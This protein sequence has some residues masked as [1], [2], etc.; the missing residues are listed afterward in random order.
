MDALFVFIVAMFIAAP[1]AASYPTLV[2]ES[3][4]QEFMGFTRSHPFQESTGRSSSF[5]GSIAYAAIT[6]S[7]SSSD[8][9][10]RMDSSSRF[11]RDTEM[12]V[13][14]GI[15][16]AAID[17]IVGA[18]TIS[19]QNKLEMD[20]TSLPTRTRV[21]GN[22]P[23][24]FIYDERGICLAVWS[25]SC[26]LQSFSKA[27][28]SPV[29]AEVLKVHALCS[30]DCWT[31]VE[32]PELFAVHVTGLKFENA[33]E[34]N[35]VKE[36][37][38]ICDFMDGSPSSVI[39]YPTV[40]VT[41][42]LKSSKQSALFI[43]AQNK[44]RMNIASPLR[45]T[46]E[47]PSRSLLYGDE[48]IECVTTLVN[49]VVKS[50]RYDWKSIP[51]YGEFFVCRLN[52]ISAT[53]AAWNSGSETVYRNFFPEPSLGKGATWNP[54]PQQMVKYQKVQSDFLIFPPVC[55]HMVCLNKSLSLDLCDPRR[56]IRCIGYITPVYPRYKYSAEVQ[57]YWALHGTEGYR[58]R[59]NPE[60]KY[61][62]GARLF[63]TQRG[64]KGY[65]LGALPKCKYSVV[66]S[67]Q[68]Q[69]GTVE[70]H[71]GTSPMMQ[72][73]AEGKK[74]VASSTG[75]LKYSKCMC[76]A[77]I[78]KVTTFPWLQHIAEG[79]KVPTF[80]TLFCLMLMC[81]WVLILSTELSV[82][83]SWLLAHCLALLSTELSVASSW[84]LAHCL[85][86]FKN[87]GNLTSYRN[88][89]E[90]IAPRSTNQGQKVPR[91]C[92]SLKS[93]TAS[94]PKFLL[95]D[96][97]RDCMSQAVPRISS[98]EENPFWWCILCLSA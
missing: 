3:P 37:T 27:L 33:L 88:G 22:P 61:S 30:P 97:Y 42:L 19:A 79:K 24:S 17:A 58:L 63:R 94:S 74:V 26:D 9:F 52:L 77:A 84:L 50:T 23:W 83:L 89:F 67:Y 8:N 1:F 85:A 12:P 32:K 45:V 41:L 4:V 66:R 6:L 90:R 31:E 82:A 43:L 65:C 18:L 93:N 69:P 29:V 28:C 54:H 25:S 2:G 49:S 75:T 59:A 91:W 68:T 16:S 5:S 95:D 73:I 39:W 15:S 92:W 64:T 38:E 53:S 78:K 98:R 81:L 72:S 62:A 20:V 21:A 46:E 80:E 44:F 40:F 70:Y 36:I 47:N 60:C 87:Q 34:R 56:C 10:K 55:L 14:F 11:D 35:D 57:L 13:L 48:G 71:L 96:A 51:K 76:S 7:P 86:H